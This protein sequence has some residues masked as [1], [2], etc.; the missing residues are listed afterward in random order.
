MKFFISPYKNQNQNTRKNIIQLH[1]HY[2]LSFWKISANCCSSFCIFYHFCSDLDQIL[3]NKHRCR[4]FNI[5]VVTSNK[6]YF[7][8]SLKALNVW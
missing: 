8:A 6:V 2:F 1:N 5:V 3:K 4:N 7:I